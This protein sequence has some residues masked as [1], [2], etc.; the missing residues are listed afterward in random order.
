MSL[1]KKTITSLIWAFGQQF[2]VQ[3]ISFCITIGLARILMP[4]EF[5]LI[6]MLAVFIS[7]GNTLLDSGLASSLIRT[8]DLTQDDYSTVFFFNLGGSVVIYAIMYMVAP[9][10]ARLYHQALLM[11]V[12]RIYTLDFIINAFFS[13]Q[14]AR[15]TKDMNFKAQMLIQIP[16]VLIGGLVGI[17]LAVNGYGVWSLVWLGLTQSFLSTVMH[18]LYSGWVPSW[19]FKKSCFKRHFSFGYKMTLTGLLDIIYRNIYVVIIGRLY[20]VTQLGFYSRAD[21]FSQLPVTNISMVIHKV[22]YPMFA[23]IGDDDERLKRVY[24]RLM[25]QVIFWMA[26]ILI[27]MIILAEPLFV[28]ILTEKWLPAVPY[29][30]ILCLAG[31]MY[32]LNSYNLNILK[33]KGRSDLVLRLETIKKAI[34]VV[35]IFCATFFGIYGL[36]YFQLLFSFFS[37]YINSRYSSTLINYPVKEQFLDLWLILASALMSGVITY[38]FDDLVVKS[39]IANDLGRII[40]TGAFFCLTYLAA[41]LVLKL[42]PMADFKLLILKK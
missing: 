31:I 13:V 12:I 22:S 24:R 34:C 30:Q 21:A 23:E 9:L 27:V 18:W 8:Q 32:P 11:P 15:L 26:P 41:G 20:S 4:A 36:L 2:S 39:V 38:L 35:G 29:F 14:N 1:E 10:I 19:V 17:F 40:A 33:V 6:A 7:V 5:G 25:Q 42:V 37:Y 28:F 3:L 16:A